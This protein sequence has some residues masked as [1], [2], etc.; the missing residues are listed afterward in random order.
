MHQEVGCF[1]VCSFCMQ[2]YTRIR[3]YTIL[4][5]DLFLITHKVRKTAQTEAAKLYMM[6]RVLLTTAVLLSASLTGTY[7]KWS[8]LNV[9]SG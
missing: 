5:I 9:N 1:L 8:L 6:M 3:L 7:C 2:A 4:V